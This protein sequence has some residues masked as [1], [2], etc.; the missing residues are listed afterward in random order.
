MGSAGF[1]FDGRIPSRDVGFHD[2]EKGVT[3]DLELSGDIKKCFHI[4]ESSINEHQ[5][6]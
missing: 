5:T 6:T 1:S 3:C 4:A 2:T